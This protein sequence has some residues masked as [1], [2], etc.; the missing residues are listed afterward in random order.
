M[1]AQIDSN[2]LANALAHVRPMILGH[3]GDI[4]IDAVSENGEVSV[5][6]VGACK[7]CPNMAMTFVGPVRTRFMAVEGV[8]EVHCEQVN[9]G[10]KALVRIARLLGAHPFPTDSVAT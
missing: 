6:L 8:T 4:E 5:R 7:A 2:E 3:G 9:A 1:A 10:P